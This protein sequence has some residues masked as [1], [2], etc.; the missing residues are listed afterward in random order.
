MSKVEPGQRA[1]WLYLPFSPVDRL[2]AGILLRSS[3][4]STVCALGV[5]KDAEI[6]VKTIGLCPLFDVVPLQVCQ[7]RW[8]LTLRAENTS[9]KVFAQTPAQTQ[10]RP[11]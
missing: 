8:T 9:D 10:R 11:S 6:L 5:V 2:S 7:L 4:G 1:I 3:S